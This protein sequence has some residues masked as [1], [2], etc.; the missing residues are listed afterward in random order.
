MSLLFDSSLKIMHALLQKWFSTLR[1]LHRLSKNRCSTWCGGIFAIN[2][3]YIMPL[4][5]AFIKPPLMCMLGRRFYKNRLCSYIDYYGFLITHL[6]SHAI[7]I[8][9]IFTFEGAPCWTWLL[10]LV[11]RTSAF[12]PRP[13]QC[14][15]LRCHLVP[16]VVT[17]IVCCKLHRRSTL[18]RSQ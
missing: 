6:W 11:E 14:H 2:A 1:Y 3:N 18:P 4:T 9:S 8:S 5:T 13:A 17:L 16:S 12:S 7:L 10:C 15:K